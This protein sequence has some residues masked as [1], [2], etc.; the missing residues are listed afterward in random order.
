MFTVGE[1]VF[2]RQLVTSPPRLIL[3]VK[4]VLLWVKRDL[5]GGRRVSE[6]TSTQGPNRKSYS[7]AYVLAAAFSLEREF[8]FCKIWRRGIEY[9]LFALYVFR[10]LGKC[11]DPIFIFERRRIV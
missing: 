2:Q 5:G 3:P 11:Y 8:I 1:G 10:S 6:E 7:Q 4:A 9:H